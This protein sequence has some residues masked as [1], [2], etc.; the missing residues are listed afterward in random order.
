M[1]GT[2]GRNAVGP[3]TTAAQAYGPTAGA[4]INRPATGFGATGGAAPPPGGGA[5]TGPTGSNVTG[6]LTHNPTTGMTGTS[7]VAIQPAVD[8]DAQRRQRDAQDY[9]NRLAIDS[10]YGGPKM[11]GGGGTSGGGGGG[12]GGDGGDGGGGLSKEDLLDLANALKPPPPPGREAAPT[13]PATIAGPTAVAS[14]SA[15]SQGFA[16]AKDNAGRIANTALQALRSQMVARGIEGSGVEGQLASGILGETARGVSDASF[17]QERAAE[18]QA[19]QAAQLGYQGAINQ[20]GQDMG[21]A[22]SG[23]SGNINQRGQDI[24]AQPNMLALFPTIASMMQ[25]RY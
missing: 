8:L 13:P 14:P 7:G 5:Y 12:A 22:Q 9:E 15:K 21:L 25:R 19:W 2:M 23:F 6:N 17:Q 10:R 20:R 24:S 3:R 4:A 16:R 18:D 1:P 11:G